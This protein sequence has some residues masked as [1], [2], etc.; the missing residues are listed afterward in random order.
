MTA[1]SDNIHVRTWLAARKS[2]SI[3]ADPS[4]P[5][6]THFKHP[7]MLIP[8]CSNTPML[9]TP[10]FS[11]HVIWCH[12]FYSRVFHSRVLRAPCP[13]PQW[14][15][16]HQLSLGKLLKK[17]SSRS[18]KVYLLG[19]LSQLKGKSS[20]FRVGGSWQPWWSIWLCIELWDSGAIHTAVNTP[21]T[22]QT[23]Q[24][25]LKNYKVLI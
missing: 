25:R 17:L 6:I 8:G 23:A 9:S 12:V 11:A 15:G 2:I 18:R 22:R 14:P 21:G 24:Q 20:H 4:Q 10:A 1:Q 5:V 13:I 3:I 19:W 7:H 16:G